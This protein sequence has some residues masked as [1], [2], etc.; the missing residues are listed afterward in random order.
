MFRQQ[1]QQQQQK[2]ADA[3]NIPAGATDYGPCGAMYYPGGD[4]GQV[5]PSMGRHWSGGY[6][7]A[8]QSKNV[9][10]NW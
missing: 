4:S 9:T 6:E 1:G 7:A 10:D 3:S 8:G 2:S 5:M